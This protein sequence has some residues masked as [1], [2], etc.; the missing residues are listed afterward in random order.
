MDLPAYRPRLRLHECLCILEAC[1][2]AFGQIVLGRTS[3]VN[4]TANPIRKVV[5]PLAIVV[6]LL[7]SATPALGV[8]TVNDAETDACAGGQSPLQSK[9]QSNDATEGETS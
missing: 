9:A 6:G 7:L 8:P 2:A 3:F 5:A 4:S 1:E